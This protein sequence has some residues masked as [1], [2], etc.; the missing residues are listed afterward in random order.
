M[1]SFAV[2]RRPSVRN[3]GEIATHT[4]ASVLSTAATCAIA[5]R[6][7]GGVVYSLA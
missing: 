4:P 2:P 7:V 3:H 6:P 5:L 1:R